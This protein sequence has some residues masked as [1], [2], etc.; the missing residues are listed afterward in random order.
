MSLGPSETGHWQKASRTYNDK[1]QWADEK[2]CCIRYIE[3]W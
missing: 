1:G 2:L 3:A